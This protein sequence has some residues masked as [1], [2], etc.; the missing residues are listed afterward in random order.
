[1]INTGRRFLKKT[2]KEKANFNINHIDPLRNNVSKIDIPAMFISAEDDDLINP[3]HGQKLYDAYK[4]QNKTY[5]LVKGNHNTDR[6]NTVNDS[7]GVFL[8]GL[9]FENFAQQ[10]KLLGLEENSESTLNISLKKPSALDC[11]M[12]MYS[13]QN[14]NKELMKSISLKLFEASPR[15]KSFP[16]KNKDY[17]NNCNWPTFSNK[18]VDTNNDCIP[19]EDKENKQV[20]KVPCNKI[21]MKHFL[22]KQ[23]QNKG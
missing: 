14:E 1:M 10:K 2:I 7:I 6:E 4:G 19:D 23:N 16:T 22:N 8:G 17:N 13:Q 11:S 15:R 3:S 18:N 5:M 12:K 9:L 21:E 20:I